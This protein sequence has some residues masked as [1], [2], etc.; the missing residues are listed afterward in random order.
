MDSFRLGV[1]WKFSDVVSHC[2]F[3]ADDFPKICTWIDWFA[4]DLDADATMFSKR[5]RC[6]LK[7]H[8]LENALGHP[9]FWLSLV[10]MPCN[11]VEQYGTIMAYIFWS[12]F[13]EEKENC[14]FLGRF[15]DHVNFLDLLGGL[16]THLHRIDMFINLHI[17]NTQNRPNM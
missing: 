10:D 5:T 15:H 7:H 17:E 2:P 4:T 6:G 14:V 8:G 3:Q 1:G 9:C 13:E 16:N 12:R 11:V